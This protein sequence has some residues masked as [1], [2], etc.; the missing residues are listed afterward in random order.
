MSIKKIFAKPVIFIASFLVTAGLFFC[1]SLGF[2]IFNHT[3]PWVVTSRHFS[4]WT[5]FPTAREKAGFKTQQGTF[6]P[7]TADFSV[8][9]YGYMTTLFPVFR[10]TGSRTCPNRFISLPALTLNILSYVL[11]SSIAYIFIIKI[12]T[13]FLREGKEKNES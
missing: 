11:V 8:G 7:C 10:F 9:N 4:V 5:S 3:Y 1:I 13:H 6:A 2:Y 12:Y